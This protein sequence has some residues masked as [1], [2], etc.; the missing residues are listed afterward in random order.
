[1]NKEEKTKAALL[2]PDDGPEFKRAAERA[3]IGEKP[4]TCRQNV[5]QKTR[6]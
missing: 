6:K 2:M 4:A 1:M 5:A 3:E